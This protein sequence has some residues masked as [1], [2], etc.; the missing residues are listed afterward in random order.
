LLLCLHSGLGKLTRF[1]MWQKI[2][3]LDRTSQ[4]WPIG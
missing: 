1:T 2:F 3:G 4:I